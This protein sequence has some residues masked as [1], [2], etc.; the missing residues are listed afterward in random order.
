MKREIFELI[1]ERWNLKEILFAVA[2]EI[3]DVLE[4]DSCCIFLL[5]GSKSIEY[6][7]GYNFDERKASIFLKEGKEV[8]KGKHLLILSN[9]I[10]EDNSAFATAREQGV[11]SVAF[12]P[13]FLK[14]Q[15]LGF[16]TVCSRKPQFFHKQ[17]FKLLSDLAKDVVFILEKVKFIKELREKSIRDSLTGL[18]SRNYFVTRVSEEISRA[19][20][21]GESVGFLFCDI[22]NFKSINRTRGYAEG[23]RI[24]CR[25][26][27]TIKTYLREAD[28]ICR[29]GGDEFA[30]LLPHTDYL[31]AT[32]VAERINYGLKCAA[33][34]GAPYLTLSIGVVCYP[35]HANSF[36][37]IL[38]RADVSMIFAKH[39]PESK[40]ISWGGWNIPD[41]KKLRIREV[42]PEVIYTLAETADEKNSYAPDHSRLVSRKAVVLAREVG[43]NERAIRKVRVSAL[44][45]DIGN[46]AIPEYILNKPGS[47]TEEE[48]NIIKKHPEQ[49]VKLLRYIKGLEEL[50]PIVR[51]VHERWD[52]KG[53]PDGLSGEDIPLEARIISVVNAYYAML[54]ERPYRRKLSSRE[55]IKQLKD[56]AGRQFDPGIVKSFLEI[57]Q[58]RKRDDRLPEP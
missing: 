12:S 39:C 28:V 1:F 37:D 16:F 8:I 29:Y 47:L 2:K 51:S 43:V 46:M 9:L 44:L 23:D 7:A 5:S 13:L 50:A 17:D 15:P 36:E 10:D 53:Y 40:I 6:I 25:V 14:E 52:G 33:K 27:N 30:I 57:L 26:A 35:E 11:F 58:R 49:S 48:R 31:E 41:I 3:T 19:K 22:D 18:Y 38:A 54:S 34:E 21:S 56:Q 32:R 24:L 4:A 45:Q 42:L 20:R 55:T